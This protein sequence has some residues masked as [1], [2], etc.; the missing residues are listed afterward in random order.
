MYTHKKITVATVSALA[1]LLCIH[2]EGVGI[3]FT[4]SAAAQSENIF[5]GTAELASTIAMAMQ[6]LAFIIFHFLQFLLDPLFILELNG[7]EGLRN[8][9]KYSRD[10]MNI[11]FAFMLIF[12][13]IF[14]VVT[15]N[16]ELVQQKYK[17]F[18]LAVIL[19]NF[20]WFF[21]RVILDVANV[22]TATVY[23]IPAGLN[24]DS[25]V[26]CRLPLN[27]G[28]TEGRPC[29]MVN[30]MKYFNK[31]SSD[32]AVNYTQIIPN[33]VCAEMVDWN[34]QTNTAYG[35][36]NG[37]VI[38]YA[39][40][41]NL[42]RVL[43]PAG[44]RGGPADGDERFQEYL[45]FLMHVLFVL[46]LMAMLFL[47]LAAMFVV[48]LIRIPIMWFTIAFM[49]FMFIGFV[50]G[51]KLGQF[52]TMKIFQ[53]YIKA[54]FLPTV[55]A[56]PF[57][58]G[59]LILTEFTQ[60][61]CTEISIAPDLCK[62]TGPFLFNV[63]TPWQLLILLIT[64]FVI[65]SGF[66]MAIKIDDIYVNATSGIKSFGDT[67]GKTAVKLPLSVPI[68][69]GGDGQPKQSILGLDDKLRGFSS[70]L[71]TGKDPFRAAGLGEVG[72]AE[73]T[74]SNKLVNALTQ[75]GSELN[76][77]LKAIADRSGTTVKLRSNIET[78]LKDE[79]SDLS[80]ELQKQ[81]IDRT[82]VSPDE[83]IRQMNQHAGGELKK[84]LD[85]IKKADK[86]SGTP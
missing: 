13:G 11:I 32:E 70:N 56:I 6:T 24:P 77:N 4:W 76:R 82:K 17:R 23:Q 50:M 25:R 73:A 37:L 46:V 12:A 16:K 7:T 36:I 55:V 28:E 84:R 31:C 81:G 48:F 1:L 35:M 10:I 79:K 72:K 8:I 74:Q 41:P 57:A 29:Q 62:T 85:E 47:P 42:T 78:A 67:L 68:I 40:L 69:P 19:V 3:L 71:S 38:N 5:N 21:P 58:V 64:F 52:D 30:D 66:W 49:P 39:Q 44:G 34:P 45:L 80:K 14:T 60:V 59:F 15:G 9:W 51:D 54:A 18:I 53:H 65:W 33:I 75:P 61:D 20:S 2:V 26:D 63:N 27:E 83:I 43:N 86:G 22:L